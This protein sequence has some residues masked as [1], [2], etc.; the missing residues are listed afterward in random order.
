MEKK[1]IDVKLCPECPPPVDAFLW[2]DV[3]LGSDG[4]LHRSDSVVKHSIMHCAER[5][6]GHVL[7]EING[8][9][10]GP[11]LD[12]CVNCGA[13]GEFLKEMND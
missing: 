4:F 12:V 6:G 9:A 10:D 8:G 11:K 5:H 7:G 3:A 13:S 2:S 1:P